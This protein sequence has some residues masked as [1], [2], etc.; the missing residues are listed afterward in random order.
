VNEGF[1]ASGLVHVLSVS[2]LHIAVIA[3]GLYR[4]LRWLLSRSEQLL[5]A[6][7]VRSLAAV[8]AIPACWLYVVLTGAEIP[9]V[10]SGMMASAL[11]LAIA[12]GRDADG[13]SSLAAAF[14]AA[15]VW[16]PSSLHSLSFQLSFAAVAGLMLLTSPLRALVPVAK[17]DPE[18]K[19][20][21]AFVAKLR[22]AV[23][24]AAAASLA[25][26]LATAPLV[27]AAFQRASL[28]SV[29]AN[30]LALPVASALTVVA[31]C[32]AV[33]FSVWEWAA[34]PLLVLS[35]PIARLLLAI[36]HLFASL[37]FASAQVAAPSPPFWVAWYALLSAIPLF[38][39]RRRLAWTLAAPS[40][41]VLVL[42]GLARLMGPATR[43]T[44]QITFFAVGQGDAA[45]VQLPEGKNLLIDGGGEPTGHFD[46]GERIVVPALIELNA[47]RLQAAVLSHPHPDH[48]LGLLSVVR[49]LGAQEIWVARGL[50]REGLGGGCSRS[51][52]SGVWPF[53]SCPRE[54]AC[55]ASGPPKSPCSG[56]LHTTRSQA[57]TRASCSV[58]RWATSRSCSRATWKR[59]RRRLSSP[60]HWDQRPSSR[61]HTTAARRAR[62]RLSC[63]LSR[64]D[65]SSTAS[66]ARTGTAFLT[67]RSSL[68]T[69]RRAARCTAPTGTEPSPSSPTGRASKSGTT[70]SERPAD[71]SQGFLRAR[72]AAPRL[73]ATTEAS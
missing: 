11:F 55:P 12:L 46:P 35:E 19:G 68:A 40:V 47:T 6:T 21:R 56:R 36:S 51:L 44:L 22:A 34:T 42:L 59:P 71:R 25:A 14:L 70:V 9:A 15:L 18:R 13:P 20:A 72:P 3:A 58:S 66:A 43:D 4:V 23:L 69:R 2:G 73:G 60:G 27:A 61:S 5:L 26:S 38:R 28:V 63:A 53:A 37:P 24:Q 48:A 33:V 45:L 39:R 30:A 41:A 8:L 52:R 62:R 29:L 65:T 1:N 10:R 54:T 64:R 49:R 50:E 31:A 7:N 57:T 32:S 17:P 16:D 67:R